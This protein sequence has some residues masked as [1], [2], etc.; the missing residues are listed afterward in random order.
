MSFNLDFS[1]FKLDFSNVDWR[2]IITT[3]PAPNIIPTTPPPSYPVLTNVSPYKI[4]DSFF[5]DRIRGNENFSASR[6]PVLDLV[7][8]NIN[9]LFWIEIKEGDTISYFFRVKTFTPEESTKIINA[10]TQK[11]RIFF[12]I[13]GNLVIMENIPNNT[14]LFEWNNILTKS[15]PSTSD[16]DDIFFR[17][18]AIV[19]QRP[20]TTLPR[21]DFILSNGGTW[22]LY[23]KDNICYILY[24]PLHRLS[25]KNWYNLL[26]P[27]QF[28]DADGNISNLFSNYCNIQKQ[29]NLSINDLSNYS[30]RTCKCILQEDG[31]DDVTGQKISDPNYRSQMR[32]VYFCQA[33]SCQPSN[34][35]LTENSFMMGTDGY[36]PRRVRNL[37]KEGCPPIQNIICS[38]DFNSAGNTNLVGTKVSQDCGYK[39][40]PPPTTPVSVTT[41]PISVTTTPVSVTTTPISVTTS[42]VSV[43]TPTPEPDFSNAIKNISNIS[44]YI[45]TSDDLSEN[46][47]FKDEV[48]NNILKLDRTL[49]KNDI[50][51]E[52]TDLNPE[53]YVSN[54][55]YKVDIILD[56]QI[57]IIN[58]N[59][60]ADIITPQ[61]LNSFKISA[62]KEF[63]DSDLLSIPTTTPVPKKEET[64]NLPAIIIIIII[65]LL[66]G[67]MGTLFFK[68]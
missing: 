64:S 53:F 12:D 38:I 51:V 42:P 6:K 48:I 56:K 24:N 8:N 58:E 9:K 17:K 67:G 10:I 66:L 13:N 25:F 20:I 15:N 31:V 46:T 33:P 28:E 63:E 16:F 57:Q 50:S 54:K 18:D 2:T 47:N 45:E 27:T 41:T 5:T 34:L 23:T 7:S 21:L 14:I 55:K 19:S 29:R 32:G 65:L 61:I 43:T 1:N 68:K 62:A 44:L 40:P 36:Q 37:G 52:I 60:L 35:E 49:N 39:P 30:D 11:K 3:T 59:I 22:I 26:P 4:Y